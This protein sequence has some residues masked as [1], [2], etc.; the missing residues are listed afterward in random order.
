MQFRPHSVTW[1]I[2]VSFGL[3]EKSYMDGEDWIIFW[4]SREGCQ[5]P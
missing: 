4:A 5:T 1:V 3:L 2:L